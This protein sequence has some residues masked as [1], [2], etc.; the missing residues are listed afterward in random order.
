[1]G[2]KMKRK[3]KPRVVQ[4]LVIWL[5]AIAKRLDEWDAGRN[6][7]KPRK[8]R[9]PRKAKNQPELPLGDRKNEQ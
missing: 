2:D 6:P 5:T 8:P 1:M 3:K 4:R 9:V 7:P